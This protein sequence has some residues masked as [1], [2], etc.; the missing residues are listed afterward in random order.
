MGQHESKPERRDVP[1][2][3]LSH[4]LALQFASKC[5]THLEIAHFKDNFKTLADHQ[6]DVE[7]WKEETLCRFLAL[8]DSIRAGSVVYAMTNYLGAFPFPSLAPC[9]VTREAMLK[10]VT[11]LTGRYKKVLKRGDQDK[12]K[13]LF[14]SL[15]VF[16]RR[17]SV[18]VASSS[19]KG[20]SATSEEKGGIERS[21]S[22]HEGVHTAGGG[23]PI[24]QPV[25]DEEEE[26]D[27]DLALAALDA[28]D[29]IEVFKE[30][31][32][33]ERKIHSAHVPVYNL[34]RLIMLMLAFA[35]LTPQDNTTQVCG[36][37]LEHQ[38]AALERA[39]RSIIVAFEPEHESI[40]YTNFI[41]TITTVTPQL[42]RPLNPLFEHFLFSKHLNPG[43][44]QDE[45]SEQKASIRTPLYEVQ[46]QSTNILND[47]LLAQLSFSFEI[48]NTSSPASSSFFHCGARLNQLYSTASH[49][50]SLSSFGRQVLSWRAGT[51]LVL[52]GTDVK[53]RQT[54]IIGAYLP[55]HWKEAGSTSQAES[56]S[57]IKATMFQL[58]PRHAVFRANKYNKSTPI[59]YFSS[60]T[61]MALGGI[62]PASSR[63]NASAQR[64]ALG[65]VSLVIDEDFATAT[66]QHDGDAG[67]A[68]A[69]MTDPL[70]EETQRTKSTMSTSTDVQPTKVTLDIDDLEVWGVSF[71]NDGAAGEDEITKQKKRLAWEEAEAA[72][73]RGVNFGGD[74]DG[75]RHLLEMAGVV[76]D[77][78]R[79]G[80]SMG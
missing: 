8:P 29:A 46:D 52:R 60:K 22:N 14:R 63:I 42:F 4:E 21:N 69:F 16:D 24:D 77:G 45:G 5:Y 25:N 30:D 40:S 49:G 73:R 56:P 37:L 59:S 20:T 33:K 75:A 18:V 3:T 26:D 51:L 2:E 28:L 55:D 44:H 9:I 1:I 39:A 72:R 43:K 12:N 80:G 74:K 64:P 76:G 71:V 38:L 70:L 61:G 79:S 7:Y 57:E 31:Q 15:A 27:D 67:S 17:N 41:R 48:T 78:N 34:E 66:F 65:P 68:G 53:S 35:S 54:H 13:L 19:I 23:F 47:V 58:Q 32:K 10:V 11:L 36:A 50:T 6:D 62:I